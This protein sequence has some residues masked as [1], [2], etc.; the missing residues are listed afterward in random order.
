MTDTIRI[1]AVN[2]LNSKPLIYQPGV[3]SR[4][5]LS[6]CSIIQAGW[7]IRCGSWRAG[8]GSDPGDRVFSCGQLPSAARTSPLPAMGRC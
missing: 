6:W 8:C 1:G 3:S 4:R 5:R 7:R 2:Y